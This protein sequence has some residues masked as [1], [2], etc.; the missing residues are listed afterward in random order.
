M[1]WLLRHICS[2]IQFHGFMSFPLL[3][4]C[5]LVMSTRR[6]LIPPT[7]YEDQ[8]LDGILCHTQIL[9]AALHPYSGT[10]LSIYHTM[11]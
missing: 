6:A 2:I 10:F 9:Q 7:E 8:Q 5:T 11:S 3:E 4:V 1:C